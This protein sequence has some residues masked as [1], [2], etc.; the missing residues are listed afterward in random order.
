MEPKKAAEKAKPKA[1]HLPMEGGNQGDETN[2]NLMGKD[3]ERIAQR[4]KEEFQGRDNV[5][6]PQ[7]WGAAQEFPMVVSVTEAST[8]ACDVDVTLRI[9]KQSIRARAKELASL[10]DYKR[11]YKA[12]D[13]NALLAD[14]LVVEVFAETGRVTACL[15]QL[16][17][18]SNFGVDHKRNRNAASSIVVG[19][20]CTPKSVASLQNDL[21]LAVFLAPPCGS[22][23]RARQIPLKQK[24]FGHPARGQPSHCMC[25]KPA[26]QF[27]L[28][29]N[30]L[31]ASC[32][33]IVIYCFSFMSVRQPS[34]KEN[35]VG[36]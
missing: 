2:N 26:V 35:Y 33:P 22:T 17:L 7:T 16:E 28:G 29:D 10:L 30:I 23:F 31:A 27:V 18:G 34:P 24:R 36:F 32:T 4:A 13:R 12:A 3:L 11:I 19:D 20:L 25:G 5:F 15:Q 14:C 6:D 8:C 1:A 9:L 21:V